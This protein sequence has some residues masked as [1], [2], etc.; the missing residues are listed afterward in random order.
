M[1]APSAGYPYRLNPPNTSARIVGDVDDVGPLIPP[2]SS[3]E[4]SSDPHARKTDNSDEIRAR[5]TATREPG[6]P[7]LTGQALEQEAAERNRRG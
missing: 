2:A 5:E 3:S 1:G 4:P 7:R 6:P